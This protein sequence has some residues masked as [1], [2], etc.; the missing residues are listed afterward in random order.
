[1]MKILKKV[2]KQ[3]EFGS[4]HKDINTVLKYTKI[5]STHPS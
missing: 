2:D 5:Y 4:S 1:M 3:H